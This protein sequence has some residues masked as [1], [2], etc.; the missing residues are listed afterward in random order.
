MRRLHGVHVPHTKHTS[1]SA[2][3]EIPTPEKVVLPMSMHMGAPCIPTVKPRQKVCVGEV[4]GHNDAFFSVDIHATVSGTVSAINE[5]RLANGQSCKAVEITADGEQTPYDGIEIPTYET[6][7]EFLACVRKSGAVGLGGAG[8]PTHVKLG[9]KQKIEFLLINAAECEPYITSDD[10]TMQENQEKIITGIRRIMKI[11]EIPECMIGVENNKPD[12]IEILTREAE[13]DDAI[14]IVPL[15]A[16]YPQGAEKVLIFHTTG[17]IVKEGELPSDQGVIVMN[18][19]TVAFLEDYFSTGMPLV[20]RNLTVDG[21]AIRKP[22]NLTVPI[23][24]PIQKVLE[25]AECD[26]EALDSLIGGGPMMGGCLPN[27]DMPITKPTNAVLA[28]KACK[29]VTRTACIRCG[30]CVKACP[31][32]LMPTALESAYTARSKEELEK[33]RLSLCMLCGCCSFVCPA[34]RPLAETN[35]LAKDFVRRNS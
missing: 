7:E 10:R 1:N 8:F 20:M 22:C 24:T 5:Y 2:F 28:M 33:L 17:R 12:A 9:A 19:S 32:K 16:I 15:P 27:V 29:P 14:T 21:T 6:K 30:R 26:F 35:R 13:A 11:L 4:V 25:I 34:N 3:V 18:V 23:G 31:M